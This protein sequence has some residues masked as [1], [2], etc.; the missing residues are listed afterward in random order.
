MQQW[1]NEKPAFRFW[2]RPHFDAETADSGGVSIEPKVVG[3]CGP[4][5]RMEVAP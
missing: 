1:M 3:K 2:Y 4:Q 5:R